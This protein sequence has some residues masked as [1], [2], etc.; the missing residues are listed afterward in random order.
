MNKSSDP[1]AFKR[2]RISLISMT[3]AGKENYDVT[4]SQKYSQTEI[5]Q[6]FWQENVIDRC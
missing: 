1:S 2:M 6:V 5:F 4:M 3:T